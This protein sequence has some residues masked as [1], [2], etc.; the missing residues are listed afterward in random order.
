M[1]E[2]KQLF[3]SNDVLMINSIL[4][5]KNTKKI[6]VQIKCEIPAEKGIKATV[7]RNPQI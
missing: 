2:L 6:E 7:K 4:D 5:T 3:S 1:I